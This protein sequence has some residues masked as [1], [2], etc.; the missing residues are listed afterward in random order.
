MS[1]A[2]LMKRIFIQLFI[3][4]LACLPLAALGQTSGMAQGQVLAAN[5]RPIEG[6]G[7]VM[8]L[9]SDPTQKQGVFS[10]ANGNFR[11]RGLSPGAYQLKV[12]AIGFDTLSQVVTIEAGFNRLGR[13]A[14]S[15]RTFTADVVEIEG[16]EAQAQQ[17][18]DTTQ[19]NASAFK[20]NPDAN[21]EDL[22]RKMPG[23]T[24]DGGRVNAQGEQVRQVLV[25]GKPF[26][27]NDPNAALKTLPADV[28]QKI[29]V[30]DE[31]SEQSKAT[32]FDDGNTTKTINI[33]TKPETR[34][35]QFGRAYA[36][37]GYEDVYKAGLNWNSFQDARRISVV[38]QS[39]N[40]N[41]QNFSEED[42]LGV[43][44]AGQGRRRRPWEG[45]GAGADVNDF[46]ISQ[47]NGIATTHAGGINYSDEWGDKLEV[48]A[49]YFTNYSDN[50]ALTNLDRVYFVEGDSGLVYRELDTS[51]SV[52]LNHRFNL[53]MEYKPNKRSSIL[54]RPSISFQQNSGTDSTFG[55][56]LINGNLLSTT[57]NVFSS[58]L[59]G[60]KIDNLLFYRYRFE[61]RG[62]SFT[63]SAR[64]GYD[65]QDGS[66]QLNSGLEFLTEPGASLDTLN[67]RSNLGSS[68]IDLDVEARYTEPLGKIGLLLV[69][70]SYAPQWNES[71]RRTY[72]ISPEG[73]SSLLTA[74]SSVFTNQY[75]AHRGGLGVILRKGRKVFFIS[76][77]NYQRA[78][79]AGEQSFPTVFD[80]TYQFNNIIP[81]ALFRWRVNDQQNLRVI[82]R[83]NTDVPTVGQLQEVIDNSNPFQLTTGNPILSQAYSH[84]LTVRYGGTNTKTSNVFYF[85]LNSTFT[86]D[87]IGTSSLIARR[88]T[89]LPGGVL[90]QQGGQLSRPVNLDG[91][92]QLN[93]FITYGFPAKFIKSNLNFNLSGS[94][95]RRP[96]MINGA[97]N[98]SDNYA[99]GIGVT[100]SSNI[101]KN[102]DFTLSSK[103]DYNWAFNE[104][105]PRLNTEYFSQ[106]SEARIN[107]IFG[108]GIVFRTSVLHQY[109]DG[110]SDGVDPNYI[111]WNLSVAKKL[112]KNQRGEI[113]L[114]AFDVLGQ[115]TSV[116]RNVAS[117]YV[118]DLQSQVLQ[119]YF[120]L[121][122]TY[123]LRQF[124]PSQ[125][126]QRPP[127]PGYGP[128]RRP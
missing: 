111:L 125:E 33:V 21:A 16:Q 9:R 5:D 51:R 4:S 23:I 59:Q 47:R 109:I 85:L 113:E 94:Y 63:L 58:D 79:L 116:S 50:Q 120:M 128:P 101:S 41:I 49:S 14:L 27:G 87:F 22:I 46:L 31:Q 64:T 127:Y 114:T 68:G 28:I 80:S 104:L 3:I 43:A 13:F 6:A 55:R 89:V 17:K 77:V 12:S 38:G 121:T 54:L 15:E 98:F 18:G 110:L 34:N 76:R 32:G 42:L 52:N 105:Q 37:A 2:L 30:F 40:I 86:S 71:D 118:E 66:S 108:P 73:D 91:Y 25:D 97:L 88:D 74:Q 90:L 102:V 56:N 78:T 36:G 7:V 53:R 48:N 82:Y 1:E 70:Y 65:Q 99:T 69:N 112:F 57:Q 10:D 95:T 35:G 83:G 29:E 119:Q 44:S 45:G 24:V 81:F 93:S 11:L 122:F 103:S 39:N 100:L 92:R 72:S 26:F 123:Q 75:Y 106:V 124:E 84:R 126:P 115:N 117:T 8:T 20:T 67:Q 60:L 62:R 61:K 107:L 96:G 19:Y